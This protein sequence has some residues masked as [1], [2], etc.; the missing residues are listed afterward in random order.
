MQENLWNIDALWPCSPPA[1]GLQVPK[2]IYHQDKKG[3]FCLLQAHGQEI[4]PKQL[5]ATRDQQH[6]KFP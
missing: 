4:G 3:N 1:K 6:K 2:H 5:L